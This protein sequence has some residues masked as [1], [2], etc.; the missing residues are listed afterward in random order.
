MTDIV[1]TS[2]KRTPI[3]K[4]LGSLS[5][6]SASELG[7]FAIDSVIEE[8]KL[9]KNTID[10]VIMGQVL[11]GGAGQN[12][13]RQASMLAG[14]PI[15]KSA[16][17]VNQVCGSGLRAVSLAAQSI[18][19]NQSNIVVAGGQES[20]SN[21]HHTI[22]LRNGLKMGDGNIKD[23]MIVDGLWCAMNDYHMGT[24]AE[25]IAEKY[26][27]SKDDQDQFATESQNKTE[28]AQKKNHFNNEII[29]IEIKSK[30]ETIEFNSDEFP[31]H[32][33]TFDKINS[34]KPVFKKE[35]TVSAGNASGLNDGSAAVILMNESKANELNLKPLAR[36]VSWA[37]VGVD[38]TIMGIGP[39]PAV[40]KALEVANWTL[41]DLDVI[42]ANE[43]FAAQSLAVS[44]ELNWDLSK[45]NVNGGAI[46]LGHP[47]GASGTR[48][49]VTLI[50][51]LVRS[52]K[53]KG[54]ATLC[55]GGGQGIAMC[56]ERI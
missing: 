6:F 12:P 25:N 15:E 23:S 56:I 10:E 7:K 33:T 36:I 41:D 11:T 16:L 55:I 19:T 40:K 13:A 17:T 35:G 47:I 31:R 5:N 18:L 46:A 32:G 38:P 54:I 42:E 49:L 9:D 43:A 48:V 21:A 2:A 14:I 4:F 50:H 51:E 34:L 20:M 44:K 52:N 53:N 29:P 26:N 45:V 22:N 1:I 8:C 24:T 27:I 28:N 3:G 37:T 30:K 39:V